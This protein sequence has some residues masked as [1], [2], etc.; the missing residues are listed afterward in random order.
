MAPKQR[1][2]ENKGYPK[3]WRWKHGAWRYRVPVGLEHEWEGKREFT[4]G[5]TDVEAY[6]TWS[7]RLQL[8]RQ[9]RTIAELLERY[10]QQVVPAKAPRTQ[11]ANT[12]TIMRLR[13]VFEM[14][15]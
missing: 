7:D 13:K 3:G 9:V 2:N 1:R 4:L 8:H 12:E 15:L 6:K 10:Q 11:R 5:R 14:L